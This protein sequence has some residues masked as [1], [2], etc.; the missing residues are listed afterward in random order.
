M[1]GLPFFL[2]LQQSYPIT[3]RYDGSVVFVWTVTATKDLIVKFHLDLNSNIWLVATT[4][5]RAGP[6]E[7]KKDKGLFFNLQGFIYFTC[8]CGKFLENQVS[9]QWNRTAPFSGTS[10]GGVRR[11]ILNRVLLQC[12]Y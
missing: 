3:L 7:A 11:I 1:N 5:D 12:N 9:K 8:R 2:C 4:Q 10:S 6:R